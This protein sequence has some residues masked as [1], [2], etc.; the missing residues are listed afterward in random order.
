MRVLVILYIY[1]TDEI[2]LPPAP[3]VVSRSD[4][5]MYDEKYFRIIENQSDGLCLFYSVLHFLKEHRNSTDGYT[6]RKDW[7]L[8]RKITN[9]ETLTDSGIIEHMARFVGDLSDEEFKTISE[10]FVYEQEIEFERNIKQ[11]QTSIV[12][13]THG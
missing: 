12:L 9:F 3:P 11:Y 8:L 6:L 10:I 1:P 7:E 2:L 4:L 5:F 13:A